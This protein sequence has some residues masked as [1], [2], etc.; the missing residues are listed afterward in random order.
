MFFEIILTRRIEIKPEEMGPGLKERVLKKLKKTVTGSLIT[1]YGYVIL[2]KAL[3]TDIDNGHLHISQGEID[4][5]NGFVR[6]D[7]YY[8]AIVLRPVCGEVV[9]AIIKHTSEHGLYASVGPVEIFVSYRK[10]PCLL[11]LFIIL[12]LFCKFFVKNS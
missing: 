1:G 6:Y 3:L 4:Y 10:F 2:V 5:S 8:K 11:M 7:V 12:F 9:D